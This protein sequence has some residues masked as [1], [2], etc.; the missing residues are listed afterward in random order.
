MTQTIQDQLPDIVARM[1][2]LGQDVHG[3]EAKSAVG[4]L[5]KSIPETLS[6][7]ANGS[8]GIILLG[9]DERTGFA[10]AEG[11][12]PS[13]IRDALA[14]ACADRMQPP[15][16]PV[17]EV[18]EF[19]GAQLV[20]A[21]IEP[22]PPSDKPC[23]I[24]ERG[25]YQSSYIRTGDGDRRLSHYEIDRLVEEHRQPRWDE[26]VVDEATPGD[27]SP[28]LVAAV[29]GRQRHLRPQLFGTG[30]ADSVLEALHALKR[31]ASGALRPTLAG[32]LALGTYP[33]F[34]FPRLSVTFASFPSDS[35][36]AMING[37]ERLLDSKSL[38]GPIPSLI[39][40]ATSLVLRNGRIGGRMEGVFRVDVPEYP[41][42]AVREAITNALMHRDYSHLARGTQVQVNLFTDHLEFLNPGGLY[43]TVT[44]ASLGSR[45][46]SSTRNLRL[47]TL[48]EEA[49]H[50]DGGVVAENRGT[51][52][53][54]IKSQ[55]AAAKLAP[56]EA[57]DD[58]SSF[59][60]VFRS[61]PPRTRPLQPSTPSRPVIEAYIAS[62]PTA[63]TTELAQA[64]GLSRSAIGK[65][66]RALLD[67]GRIEPTHPTKSKFQKYRWV[68]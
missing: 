28:D 15:L 7:F 38:V 36:A 35:K 22:L 2:S 51:G 14:G 43:G 12:R 49:P 40:E 59:S 50:P 62:K 21:E 6:A 56:P 16:R 29:V 23:F 32:L 64:T 57:D 66:L 65:H 18:V 68:G 63:S 20:A 42:L 19:E 39:Q 33:Q 52:Y 11:F 30:D 41:P 45:G 61:A 37:N 25:M 54:M 67:A 34:Y 47:S 27:L 60:L 44:V 1:R 31:D 8:G 3:V 13:P 46:F 53:L 55:L 24:K 48:L 4:K 17:I 9:L 26:E 10:P 5:P 58:I